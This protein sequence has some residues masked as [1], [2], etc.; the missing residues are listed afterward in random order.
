MTQWSIR[1]VGPGSVCYHLVRYRSDAWGVGTDSEIAAVYHHAGPHLAL[2]VDHSEGV[3]LVPAA[4]DPHDDVLAIAI[5]I[6]LL[7]HIRESDIPAPA[8]SSSLSKMLGN[9]RIGKTNGS[10]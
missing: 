4:P 5:V 7:W 9:L 3:L 1:P 10:N 6:V 8:K 2:P